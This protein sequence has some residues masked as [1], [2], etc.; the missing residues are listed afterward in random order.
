MAEFF[1]RLF[2]S[3]GYPTRWEIISNDPLLG[4]MQIFSEIAI[5]IALVTLPIFIVYYIYRQRGG[6]APR[7]LWLFV[8]WLAMCSVVFLLEAMTF[9]WPVYRFVALFKLG[10]AAVSW[11]LII[12]LAP[13][14][15]RLFRLR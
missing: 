5:W 10:S 11:A 13:M 4:W 2:D 9:W 15:P 14:F 8:G 3:T 12:A 6:Y 1:R 7:P